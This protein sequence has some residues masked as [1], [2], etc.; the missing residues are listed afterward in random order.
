[1]SLYA[2]GIPKGYNTA[3]PQ[4]NVRQ[5]EAFNAVIKGGSVTK[6]AEALFISQPAVSKLIHAFEHSCG[7]K[8]FSRSTGRLVPTPEARQLF[9]ETQRLEIGVTRVRKTADA[10]R[11]LERGEISVAA[12]PALGMQL[13][14]RVSAKFLDTTPEVRISLFTRTSKSIE[15]SI[16]TRTADFGISLVPSDNPALHCETFC[17]I[18]MICVLPAIHRL[19]SQARIE[20]VD[21]ADE[22]FVA[23]GRDDMSSPMVETA[24]QQAGVSVRVMAEVQM[25]QAAAAMVSAGR[26]LS[27]V[28]TLISVGSHDPNIVF[29]PLADSF[30]MTVW[31]ITS[32][33]EER[34]ALS[35]KLAAAIKSMVDELESSFATKET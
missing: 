35:N 5:I 1:M 30:K 16:I 22:P 27:I 34:S 8:L 25:A 15:E 14:P 32:A 19:A 23:L 4:A 21:L 2:Y 29:R 10:I 31:L 28:P 26:A 11:N 13:L 3:M 24:L 33:F 17:E 12:F 7:F 6:A 20:F 18:S 9:V